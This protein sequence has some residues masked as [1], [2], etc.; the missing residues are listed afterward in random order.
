MKR[1]NHYIDDSIYEEIKTYPETISETFRRALEDYVQKK[2][3]IKVSASQSV[4][5]GD[6]V[7]RMKPHKKEKWEEYAEKKGGD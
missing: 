1:V 5:E 6:I 7:L 3:S 4:K 2:R